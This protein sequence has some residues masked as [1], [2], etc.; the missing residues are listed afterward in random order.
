MKENP[1]TVEIVSDTASIDL[2]QCDAADRWPQFAKLM[3]SFYHLDKT[4]GENGI[5]WR[6]YL[7]RNRSSKA[8]WVA[9]NDIEG[10]GMINCNPFYSA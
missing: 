4:G 1:A 5:A 8:R 6:L 2:C 10:G 9:S 7:R 3:T